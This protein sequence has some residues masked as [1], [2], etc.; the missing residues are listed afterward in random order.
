MAA[1]SCTNR[2]IGHAQIDLAGTVHA[3]EE[4]SEVGVDV[5]DEAVEGFAPGQPERVGLIA[6]CGHARLA[7]LQLVS[8][9]RDLRLPRL[10]LR[11]HLPPARGNE[12]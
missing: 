2:V 7:P 6:V 5:V 11:D 4:A 12:S 9:A 10:I 8:E 3:R 1:A